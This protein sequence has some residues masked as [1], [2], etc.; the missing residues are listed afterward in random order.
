MK[1]EDKAHLLRHKVYENRFAKGFYQVLTKQYREAARLFLLGEPL[2]N[3]SSDPMENMYK[4]IYT[5]IMSSEGVYIWNLHVKPLTGIGI[6]TKDIFDDIAGINVPENPSELIDHWR[7][8]ML[9]FLNFYISYRILQV[10]KTT[11]ERINATIDK[12]RDI[13]LSD[14]EIADIIK[15]DSRARELR[16]NT[17]ART[18]AT[19]AMNKAWML[20][21]ESSGLAWEKSWN[22]IRDDRTRDAHWETDPTFWIPIK[23]TFLVGGAPMAYPGDSTQGAEVG[24][25]INC[26]CFLRFRQ[27]GARTGFRPKQ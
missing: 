11:I 2:E 20:S 1:T 7:A 3:I 22:A 24:D 18:E 9:G 19:T 23:E 25:I 12:G 21:L 14:K 16:A 15:A 5:D 17:I 27:S 13:G 26:R 6:E 8:L 10:F 4:R